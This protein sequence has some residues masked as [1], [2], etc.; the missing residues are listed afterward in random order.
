MIQSCVHSGG[1]RRSASQ[2]STVRTLSLAEMIPAT[3]LA[4]RLPF[5]E[6]SWSAKVML[7]R[8]DERVEKSFL[9]V[10]AV[11]LIDHGLH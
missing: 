11:G 2:S 8:G 6:R 10:V 9:V 1:V 4:E 5:E 7:D 3:S